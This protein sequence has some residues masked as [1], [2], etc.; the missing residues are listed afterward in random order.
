MGM[1]A[2]T[3]PAANDLAGT[4]F[5]GPRFESEWDLRVEF[6]SGSL[7]TKEFH[8]RSGGDNWSRDF[9]GDSAL[10]ELSELV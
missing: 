9:N 6:L 5:G 8:I 2:I 4:M 10:V 7:G 3:T 1:F